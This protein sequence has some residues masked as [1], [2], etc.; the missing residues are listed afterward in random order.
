MHNL[1]VSRP[2]LVRLALLSLVPLILLIA[3]FGVTLALEYTALGQPALDYF[4]LNF[5][6][7][8][9]VTQCQFGLAPKSLIEP[10]TSDKYRQI[11]G[12]IN[13]VGWR[14]ALPLGPVTLQSEFKY[15]VPDYEVLVHGGYIHVDGPSLGL[16]YTASTPAAPANS[17]SLFTLDRRG[18]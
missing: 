10:H 5:V 13:S 8:C 1:V 9:Q 17:R 7:G 2:P 4:S 15:E 3:A 18:R 16:A 14:W 11:T 12:L 6:S